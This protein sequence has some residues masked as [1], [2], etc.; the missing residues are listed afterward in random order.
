MVRP[1]YTCWP[2]QVRQI[3]RCVVRDF[4]AKLLVAGLGCIH[5]LLTCCGSRARKLGCW[6]LEACICDLGSLEFW[7]SSL[8]RNQPEAPSSNVENSCPA[9]ATLRQ[10]I[11]LCK[12]PYIYIYIYLSLSLSLSV[13]LFI[14]T[15]AYILRIWLLWT[16]REVAL[17][18][19]PNPMRS[20]S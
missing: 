7:G 11:C 17:Q 2:T 20:S 16:K 9:T 14:H 19:L 4:L 8:S 15:H 3:Y 5:I 13:C 6:S 1:R 12:C 18:P 10:H